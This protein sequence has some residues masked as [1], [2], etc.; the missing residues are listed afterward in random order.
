VGLIT[1]T[2]AAAR[3]AFFI[4]VGSIKAMKREYTPESSAKVLP[5]F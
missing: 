5:S 1:N 4:Y 3:I 2:S